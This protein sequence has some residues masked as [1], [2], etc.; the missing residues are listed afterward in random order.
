MFS[1]IDVSVHNGTIDWNK[2]SQHIDFAILRA[3]YGKGNVD[4]MF[5]RNADLCTKLGIPFGAYWFSYALNEEMAVKEADYCCDVIEKYKVLYPVCYDWEYD[6][7]SYAQR[8]GIN[9]SNSKRYN[10]ARAF[11]KRIE[12]RG[13]YAMNYTNIDYLN[14]GFKNLTKEF[15]TWLAQWGTEKPSVFCGIWQDNENAWIEGV[16]YVDSNI[17]YNDYPKIIS[18]MSNKKDKE[19]YTGI[20]DIVSK[21][22]EKYIDCACEVLKDKYGS[23]EER[24]NVLVS[25]GYDYNYVQ[26]IVNYMVRNGLVN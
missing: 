1:G 5:N 18:E 12:E 9:M 2:V 20:D 25:L 13:Y 4:S 8:N 26:D 3:G 10:F 19:I 24:K 15:D 6:S 7:D 17:S 14:K 21:Y 16:G 22:G 23:G 11:L